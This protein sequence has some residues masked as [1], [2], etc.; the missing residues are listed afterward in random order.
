V[1]QA[2]PNLLP[3]PNT[4]PNY[5]ENPAYSCPMVTANYMTKE[6]HTLGKEKFFITL[7]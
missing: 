1:Q 5:V 3:S 7:F 6:H 4:T 2:K